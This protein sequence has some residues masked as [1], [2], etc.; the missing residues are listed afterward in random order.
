MN[1]NE[2]QQF[3]QLHRTQTD[4]CLFAIQAL[5][6]RLILQHWP[7]AHYKQQ[8]KIDSPRPIWSSV[9]VSDWLTDWLTGLFICNKRISTLVTNQNKTPSDVIVHNL[10]LQNYIITA[11]GICS[12][13][14]GLR[15]VVAILLPT[16]W[17]R[18]SR[19]SQY[20]NPTCPKIK[21]SF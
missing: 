2:T 10:T 8:A 13:Q 16:T 4:T 17:S 3:W 18:I 7:T 21:G 14:H 11:L 9:T 20:E 15:Q 19:S 5:P 12:P 6:T 1:I